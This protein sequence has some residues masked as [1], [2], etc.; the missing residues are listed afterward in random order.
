VRAALAIL[1]LAAA[2][3]PTEDRVAR[4][5]TGGN[6]DR[7][8]EAVR[9]YGCVACHEVPGAAGPRGDVGPSLEGLSHRQSLAGA[10]PASAESLVEWVRQ[11]QRLVPGNVMPDLGVTPDDARDIAAYLLGLE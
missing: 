7:G 3:R 1:L 6:A 8:R 4:Q 9:W 11:P 2:C 10:L 5:L